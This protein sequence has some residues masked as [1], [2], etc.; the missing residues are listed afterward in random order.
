MYM[1]VFISDLSRPLL[2]NVLSG[3][4]QQKIRLSFVIMSHS[5][6]VTECDLKYPNIILTDFNT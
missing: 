3:S 1:C 2:C 4:N 5:I 6:T